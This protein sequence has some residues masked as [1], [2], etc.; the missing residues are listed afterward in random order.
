MIRS[1]ESP[2]LRASHRK[3][4]PRP[5]TRG[6][7][8]I[9][10]LV[11]I[12]II[13][14]LIA[15]LLPAVQSAREAARRSQCLNNMMQ[16]AIAMVN[17]EG[18]HEILPPGVVN[19]SGPI[20]DQPKGYHFGWLA[21][22]LPHCELRNVYNHLNFN[23]GLYEAQNMTTRADVIG[24][25]LCPSDTGTRRGAGGVGATSYV[26]CHNDVEAPIASTNNGVLFLNSAV[27]IEDIPDGTSQTIF[28]S[29]KLND[30]LDQGWASGTRASLRNTGGGINGLPIKTPPGAT[31]A[32]PDDTAPTTGQGDAAITSGD[33][34]RFVGGFG[35]R[36]PG[37]C[38]TAFG[39][40][41]VRFLKNSVSPSV[42]RLLGNRADGEF[43][44]SEM[45]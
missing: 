45:Y 13:A 26:G 30:G 42:L 8:L 16:L 28:L 10:L 32:N 25:F 2:D 37:G 18:S 14:V 4:R 40:G 6:F 31:P 33:A 23:V 29:E 43:V 15:L 19:P 1:M 41:S 44:S 24:S 36:H 21:Q 7:T 17:Y 39:D 35:S 34:L 5:G 38:N 12:A 11:V 20:L 27:R 3:T 22:I 9:E